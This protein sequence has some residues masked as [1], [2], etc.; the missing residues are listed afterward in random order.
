MDP[1]VRDLCRPR[2]SAHQCVLLHVLSLGRLCHTRLRICRLDRHRRSVRCLALDSR[3]ITRTSL[4]DCTV[5]IGRC[6]GTF[7]R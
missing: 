5:F 7:A 3:L 2:L 1:M 6:V 4:V